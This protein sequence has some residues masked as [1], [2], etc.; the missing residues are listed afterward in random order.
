[1][2]TKEEFGKLWASEGAWG[3]VSAEKC[4][5]AIE[6][7][8]KEFLKDHFKLGEEVM[9]FDDFQEIKC[10][11]RP[12]FIHS[13]GKSDWFIGDARK[14]GVRRFRGM[15]PMT[16]DELLQQAVQKGLPTEVERE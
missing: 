15:R 7:D 1:M 4:W 16:E 9:I 5:A 11:I 6:A 12:T 10:T 2:L 3:P 13:N 14:L 8:R